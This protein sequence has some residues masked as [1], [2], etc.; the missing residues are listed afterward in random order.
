MQQKTWIDFRLP[1]NDDRLW[2][3]FHENSKRRTFELELRSKSG[4]ISGDA[5]YR[6]SLNPGVDHE[7]SLDDLNKPGDTRH[8]NSILSLHALAALLVPAYGMIAMED[9]PF[10]PVY[11]EGHCWPVELYLWH[12]GSGG[13]PQGLYY[14]N[15]ERYTIV[16]MPKRT[17]DPLQF[18]VEFTGANEGVIVF[19]TAVFERSTHYF[20]ERG[21]RYCLLEA[22]QVLANLH[23]L[24][25]ENNF[26]ADTFMEFH[27]GRVND[28]LGI[29]GVRHGALG[30]LSLTR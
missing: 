17:Q 8:D 15:P 27:D 20:G 13:L 10:R 19:V 29:D 28:F 18:A 1:N 30:V 25:E 12:P 3:L 4:E 7:L 9:R 23:R 16:R 24:A 26:V 6:H 14:F 22:G 2:E 21:Y 5:I 11:S